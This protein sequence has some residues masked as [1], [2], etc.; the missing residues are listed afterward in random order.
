MGRDVAIGDD[1]VYVAQVADFAEPAAAE[2]RAVGQHDRFLCGADHGAVEARLHEVGRREPVFEVDTVHAQVE[3]AAREVLQHPFGID[4]DGR[5]RGVAHHA[6]QLHHV[7]V[8]VAHEDRDDVD[9]RG[10]DRQPPLRLDL[11]G[12]EEHRGSRRDEDRVVG[13][14]ERR[15]ADADGTLLGGVVFLLFVD[16]TVVDI[17]IDQ[18]GAS[19]GAVEHLLLFEQ[20]EILADRHL[21]HF[22]PFG[23]SGDAYRALL[24]QQI[25]DEIVSFGQCHN[26]IIRYI[27]KQK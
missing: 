3:F 16:R 20:R 14:D 21:R 25:H 17:G 4:P 6:T 18:N 19:V 26:R 9:R 5:D 27:F 2:L 7:D 11:A 8:V 10:D 12:Q 13:R 1:L 23:Q 22:E 15:G 24:L